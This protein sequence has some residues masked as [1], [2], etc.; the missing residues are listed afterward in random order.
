M[1]FGL[2][3]YEFL[4]E[5]RGIFGLREAFK[6]V[7]LPIAAGVGFGIWLRTLVVPPARSAGV[8]SQDQPIAGA[9]AFLPLLVSV[10]FVSLIVSEDRYGWLARLQKVSIGGGGIE[11]SAQAGASTEHR[12]APTPTLANVKSGESKVATL[13]RFMR[14]LPNH[15]KEDIAFHDELFRAALPGKPPEGGV[16]GD[17]AVDQ[18]ETFGNDHKFARRVAYPIGNIVEMMHDVRRYN[19]PEF[20]VPRHFV[21][22]FRAF[23]DSSPRSRSDQE[24]QRGNINKIIA[25]L[26]LIWTVS[27][28]IVLRSGDDGASQVAVRGAEYCPTETERDKIIADHV[29]PNTFNPKL[30]YGTILSALMLDAIGEPHAALWQF[31]LWAQGFRPNLQEAD[32]RRFLFPRYRLLTHGAS[33]DFGDGATAMRRLSMGWI[34][35]SLDQGEL[36]LSRVPWVGFSGT[37]Y[38]NGLLDTLA[39]ARCHGAT[40]ANFKIFALVHFSYVNSYLYFTSTS[41]DLIDS[42]SRTRLFGKR[43]SQLENLNFSCL[44]IHGQSDDRF[45]SVRTEAAFH[46]TIA[47]IN[48]ALA[49]KES[50]RSRRRALLCTALTH[51]RDA[52]SFQDDYLN[53]GHRRQVSEGSWDTKIDRAHASDTRSGYAARAERIDVQLKEGRDECP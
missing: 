20:V 40:S 8:V 12:L 39:P 9:R 30:P 35:E 32:G 3:L 42:E 41:P 28:E 27:C 48:A 18:D 17:E 37:I 14:N 10:L 33:L 25:G 16:A 31:D 53:G 2:A 22:D 23:V 36:I 5:A 29:H 44:R 34:R 45:N 6:S 19:S 38:K 24:R 7:L 50:S 49:A 11:F 4:L 15:I 52:L 1:V 46:D 21:D 26:K 43:M 13:L 47:A 51:A